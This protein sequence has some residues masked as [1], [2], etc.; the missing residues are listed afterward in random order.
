MTTFF[1]WTSADATI[2]FGLIL[3][4]WLL[5]DIRALLRQLVAKRP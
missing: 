3:I 2:I 5:V 1:G 4:A